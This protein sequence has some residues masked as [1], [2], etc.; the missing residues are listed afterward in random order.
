MF[1][2]ASVF[3]EQIESTV[4][5]PTQAFDPLVAWKG[6]Q[7]ALAVL[8]ADGPANSSFSER[9]VQ[10]A[11]LVMEVCAKAP[12]LALAAITLVEF[13]R[14]SL[15]HSLHVA[16]L[17]ELIA[18]RGDFDEG[19]RLSLC[20]AALTENIAMIEL[21][22]SLYHQDGALSAEQ[23]HVVDQHPMAGAR[24]LQSRG[25]TDREWLRA[26]LEHHETQE[27][28]GYP[29][30][31]KNPSM[32][33]VLIHTCDV[34]A[35]QITG[36]T[37]RKAMLAP[38]AAKKLYLEMAQNTENPFAALLIKEFGMYVPGTFVRL[39]NGEVGV[40]RARNAET[41]TAPQVSVLISAKG[42]RH[43]EPVQRQTASAPEFKVVAVLPRDSSMMV[44]NFDQIWS[45]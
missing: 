15:A 43:T 13:R 19:A 35:S 21:Q 37:Y 44:V 22:Q 38:D 25:V 3:R 33:A 14:Y 7:G 24:L 26:V 17:C 18:R 1:V 36:R 39:A 10:Q 23:R 5:V 8:L 28:T 29:R 42:L 9:V 12:D 41:A 27:G 40:V 31:I 11:Q 6:I 45:W 2:D 4:R 16:V 32:L 30:H 34:Y 20:C